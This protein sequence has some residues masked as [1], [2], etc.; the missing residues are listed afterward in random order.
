MLSMTVALTP[1]GH[2]S[3]ITTQQV[4]EL[5][6]ELDKLNDTIR[7]Q[8]MAPVHAEQAAAKAARD[9]A[10]KEWVVPHFGFSGELLNAEDIPLNQ[11]EK[12]ARSAGKTVD[13]LFGHLDR[14]DSTAMES[15]KPAPSSAVVL[16]KVFSRYPNVGPGGKWSVEFNDRLIAYIAAG[17]RL[18]E[19][20][21]IVLLAQS[22]YVDMQITENMSDSQRESLQT[23]FQSNQLYKSA[24]GRMAFW[25]YVDQLRREGVRYE[26]LWSTPNWPEVVSFNLISSL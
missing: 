1:F 12:V 6:W 2:A 21:A 4:Q 23:A 20:E 11:R 13:Q 3:S 10:K 15:P 9:K 18:L 16:A 17:D 7:R 25:N 8:Q 26:T 14:K 19:E 24:A 5:T 22:V